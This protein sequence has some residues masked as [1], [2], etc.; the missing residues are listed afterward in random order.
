VKNIENA[1]CKTYFAASEPYLGKLMQHSVQWIYLLPDYVSISH[2]QYFS[3][4]LQLAEAGMQL[5]QIK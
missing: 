1:I 3:S 2:L 5:Y 4:C